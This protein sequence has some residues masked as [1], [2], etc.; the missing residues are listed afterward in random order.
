MLLLLLV[1]LDNDDDENGF[2]DDVRGWDF[3]SSDNDP[4]HDG[5]KYHGSHTS[6]IAASVGNN[7][8][9]VAGVCWKCK[10]MPVKIFGEAGGSIGA[11]EGIVYAAENGADVISNSW[12]GG[13]H[14]K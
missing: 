2:T 11:S 7:E 10:I 4:L 1:L 6:G 12:G 3:Y 14:S 5:N 9:G 8:I 13:P